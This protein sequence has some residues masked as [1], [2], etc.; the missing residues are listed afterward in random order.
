MRYQN[1]LL[2]LFMQVA[3]KSNLFTI[4][5]WNTKKIGFIFILF[6]HLCS[7]KTTERNKS[8]LNNTVYTKP[9]ADSTAPMMAAGTDF[10]ASGTTPVPWQLKM[11]FD[12]RFSF[13]ATNGEAMSMPAVTP[14][15]N[16]VSTFSYQDR[17]GEMKIVFSETPCSGV[18][19]AEQVTVL[20][21]TV[22]YSGCGQYLFDKKINGKWIMQTVN[23]TE[24]NAKQFTKG[25][26]VMEFNEDAETMLGTDGCNAISST[27]KFMGS[28][29]LFGNITTRGNL[30]NGIVK[31]LLAKQ[32]SSS[33][34]SYFFKGE[35]LV[36]YLADDSNIIFKRK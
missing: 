10:F 6:L 32:V 21:N 1:L 12:N 35:L 29:M 23:G 30:C 4:S 17:A 22:L 14:T 7:C 13:S 5:S 8:A 2:I 28:R 18:A 31:D 19:K 11:D 24:L 20:V 34:V 9:L 33:L 26:P 3:P 36:L 27:V 15:K 16:G 25:L